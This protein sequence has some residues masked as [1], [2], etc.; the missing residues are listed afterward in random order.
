[1]HYLKT[2][3]DKK[4]KLELINKFFFNK[5]KNLPKIKKIILTFH[6]KTTDLKQISSSILALEA[7][8]GQKGHLTKM[9]KSNIFL[10]I[11][12]GQPIGCKLILNK[13]KIFFFITKLLF[14]IFPKIKNFS[15]FKNKTLN[16]NT[17]SFAI[18]DIMNFYELEN[19]YHT[20]NKLTNLNITITTSSK[21]I[22]ENKWL[23]NALKIPVNYQL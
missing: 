12:K 7:I 4:L 23:L 20:F 9:K 18:K 1:M 5:T 11:R 13:K 17:F 22:K 16:K 3:H 19:H 15:G 10:K 6:C 14:E 8:T 21:E 2:F